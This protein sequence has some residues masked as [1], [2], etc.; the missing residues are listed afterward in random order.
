MLISKKELIEFIGKHFD[1]NKPIN[2]DVNG[3][4]DI[5]YIIEYGSSLPVGSEEIPSTTIELRLDYLL[6]FEDI[7]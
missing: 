4:C 6:K 7:V 2:I 1:D 3:N 5:K